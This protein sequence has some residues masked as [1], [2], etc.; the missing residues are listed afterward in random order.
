MESCGGSHSRRSIHKAEH[1]T[2]IRIQLKMT[3]PF[4]IISL[5]LR[6]LKPQARYQR[7]QSKMIEWSKCRLLNIVISQIIER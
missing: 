2:R 4:D 1:L 3:A 6:R 7:T 5:K